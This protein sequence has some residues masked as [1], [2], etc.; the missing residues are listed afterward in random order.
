MAKFAQR[1]MKPTFDYDRS[2]FEGLIWEEPN[3]K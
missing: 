1:F 3:S 2:L